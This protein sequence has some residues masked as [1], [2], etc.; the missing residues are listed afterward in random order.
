MNVSLTREQ[1]Q[2]QA[3]TD[4]TVVVRLTSELPV[5]VD[6]LTAYAALADT[7]ASGYS[8]LLENGQ[9]VSSTNPDGAF[10]ATG[11]VDHRH[12]SYIGYEP[13]AA[14]S[15]TDNDA[16]IEINDP[17]YADL[18]TA[19]GDNTIETLRDSVPDADTTFETEESPYEGGLVGFLSYDAVYDIW[20]DQRV[21]KPDTGDLPDAQFV[22][23]TKTIVFD[24]TK[25][26]PSLVFTPVVHPEDNPDRLYDRC[27]EEIARVVDRL[28]GATLETEPFECLG[29]TS[30]PR[31]EYCSAVRN[32]KQHIVDGDIYQGVISRERTY[33]GT[34]DP[35]ALYERLRAENPSPYM[36]LLQFGD[37]SVIGASPETLVSVQ[38][39]TIRSNPLAGTCQ[40]GSCPIEDRSA[41]GNLLSDKKEQ[42]EHVMLVDLA[43][44]DVRR[45]ARPGSVSVDEFMNVVKY[46]TVQHIES[47]VT[48]ELDSEYDM[49]DA[50]AATFPVGTL[51]GAPKVRAME[52]IDEIEASPRGIYG[53]G[54]GYFSWTDKMDFAIAIRTATIEH[55][56]NDHITVRA[57]AGVV[58]DS[59]PD[60]EYEE[61]E[62]KLGGVLSALDSIQMPDDNQPI[63]SPQVQ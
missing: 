40:R 31:R 14:I 18:I 27:V 35:Y 62:Q 10:S 60:S 17:R 13:A 46:T 19:D 54:V 42:A 11:A 21:D 37:R 22:L 30:S 2:E 1:F 61:T 57:G 52:I 51:S 9:K 55:R 53:G 50:L 20:L 49:F 26:H 7:T 15:V 33:E 44:N 8:F 24:H 59:D 29:S 47:V 39:G 12:F 63:T 32:A 4:E 25:H 3:D 45:V 56:E 23:N 48:G 41:A 16:T 5:S 43:R 34:L 6:P 28:D 36:Y 58:D 38:E